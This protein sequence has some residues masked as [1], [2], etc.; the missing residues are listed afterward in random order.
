MKSDQAQ[1]HTLFDRDNWQDTLI[2]LYS[3]SKSFCIPGLRLG[4]VIAGSDMVVQMGKVMD[5][6]QIC[7]PRPPQIAI[8]RLMEELKDWR[9]ENRQEI[10]NRSDAMV[11]AMKQV[12]EWEVIAIGAYFCYIRHPF[13]NKTSIE[14]AEALAKDCG[15]L[16]IPGEFFGPGQQRYLRFAFANEDVTAIK[17]IPERLKYI[18]I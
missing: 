18:K 12:P 16:T 3:F 14:V 11:S 5:N 1:P 6:I 9:E 2:Q 17:E 13:E 4:A 8:A 7:A 10:S 15:L